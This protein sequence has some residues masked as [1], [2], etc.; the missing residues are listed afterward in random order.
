MP[1]SDSIVGEFAALLTNETVAD[2]VPLFCGENVM[3]YE[4]L[5]P[6]MRF[7]GSDIPDRANSGLL[8][9]AEKTVTLAPLAL[10]VPVWMALSPTVTLPKGRVAGKTVN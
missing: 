10:R 8:L 5:W 4:V 3:V 9:V 1:V 7:R 6:A 2:A